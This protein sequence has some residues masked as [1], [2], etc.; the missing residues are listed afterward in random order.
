MNFNLNTCYYNQ[1]GPSHGI[2]QQSLKCP[3][4][5]VWAFPV[6]QKQ[7]DTHKQHVY[8]LLLQDSCHAF[9][10]QASSHLKVAEINHA[11]HHLAHTEAVAEVMEGVA[12]VILLNSKLGQYVRKLIMG[13][14]HL[15]ACK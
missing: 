3:N 12:S 13:S 2:Q 15:Y 14:M 8:V 7:P 4:L 9:S 10:K 11:I 1:D 5:S 6:D